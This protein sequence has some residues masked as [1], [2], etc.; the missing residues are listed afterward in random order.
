MPVKLWLSKDYS[1]FSTVAMKYEEILFTKV[2]SFGLW[3]IRT[4]VIFLLSSPFLLIYYPIFP[5]LRPHHFCRP[6]GFG[7]NNWTIAQWIN[8]TAPQKKPMTTREQK[9]EPCI[10]YSIPKDFP[11]NIA[12]D[13]AYS[14]MNSR[15]LSAIECE[16]G[17]IFLPETAA[18]GDTIIADFELVCNKSNLYFWSTTTFMIGFIFG[19]IFSGEIGDRIGRKITAVITLILCLAST[20]LTSFAPNIFVF[21]IGRF[22]LG[23]FVQ[24]HYVVTYTLVMEIS[25][26]KA[27]DI[28]T[29]FASLFISVLCLLWY[30]FLAY[31]IHNWRYL[32][33]ACSF[34]MLSVFLYFPFMTESP[35]WLITVGRH[36]DALKELQKAI[37]LNRKDSDIQLEAKELDCGAAATVNF[38]DLFRISILRRITLL[39]MITWFSHSMN[40]YG[41]SF[42]SAKLPGINP[43]V[44]VTIPCLVKLLFLV[45]QYVMARYLPRR[46][47]LVIFQITGGICCV[48]V[49]ILYLFPGSESTWKNWLR[50]ALMS[51]LLGLVSAGF[52]LIYVYSSELFPTSLRSRGIGACSMVSRIGATLSPLVVDLDRIVGYR[53]LPMAVCGLVSVMAGISSLFLPES[54]DRPLTESPAQVKDLYSKKTGQDISI[55]CTVEPMNDGNGI[56]T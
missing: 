9:F 39:M 36:A 19:A 3:Q 28:F 44:S 2:G 30:T 34:C 20:L 11:L 46:P 54:K 10:A 5:G 55:N 47:C 4:Y 53:W 16:R 23:A 1:P 24:G 18:Y 56:L 6:R 40:Y 45:A 49:V 15:N 25:G 50:V 26:P 8:L 37:K 31:F 14:L 41:A 27:R 52:A 38:L 17:W 13:E 35:R 43:Y 51:L 32:H 33:L 48:V 29:S 22:L 12:F 21:T 7:L 42:Y